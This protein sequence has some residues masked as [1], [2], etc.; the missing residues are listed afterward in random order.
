[1]LPLPEHGL[2][3]TDKEIYESDYDSGLWERFNLAPEDE[4]EREKAEEELEENGT[5]KPWDELR[6]IQVEGIVSFEQALA[7]LEHIGAVYEDCETM[8][9]LGGPLGIGIVPDI[10]F[11]IESQLVVG[12]I[13]ITPIWFDGEEWSP[14]TEASWERIRDL[15]REHDV[16]RLLRMAKNNPR[17]EAAK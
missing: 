5:W 9:T 8:G 17:E 16:Y 12:S 10:P 1:M 13:R 7:Y 14:P 15:F 4:E 6:E 3:H 11:N 2:S